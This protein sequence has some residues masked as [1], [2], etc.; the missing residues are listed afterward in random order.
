MTFW[1][2]IF[3]GVVLTIS[4][5]LSNALG[6]NSDGDWIKLSYFQ[7]VAIIIY[8]CISVRPHLKE[9]NKAADNTTAT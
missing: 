3:A 4:N 1:H 7:S 2:A 8:W 6:F 9:L 5:W